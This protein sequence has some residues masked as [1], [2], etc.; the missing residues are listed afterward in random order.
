MRRR[1]RLYAWVRRHPVVPDGALAAGL[2]LVFVVLS[3][4]AYDPAWAHAVLGGLMCAALVFRRVRPVESFAVVSAAGLVQWAT[5]LELTPSDVLLLVGLYS[6]SGY[7]PRW[8]SRVGL[9]T[10]FLGVA[11]AS[12]RYYFYADEGAQSV[13]ASLITFSALVVGSW[14]MGDVRRVRQAYVAELVERAHQAERDRDQRALIAAAEERARI[15]REMHDVV[16]HNLS[17]IVVQADGG[18]YAAAQDPQAA[19]DALTIIGDTGRGA[20]AEMRRLLGVLRATD[21]G[22]GGGADQ[23]IVRNPQPGL[24]SLPELVTSV[25]QAGLPVEFDVSGAPR[26]LPPG[27]SLAV[28]RVI[29]EAL[30]NALKHAGPAARAQ[31]R[32][33][34]GVDCLTAR[35]SDDGRGAA[36]AG[37][38]LGQGLLG[39]RERMT[40]YGGTVTAGPLTGGGWRVDMDMPYGEGA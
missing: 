29:Q 21:D 16:A 33:A 17:V 6:V 25:R 9:A 37:D 18:R 36:A 7:G 40:M 11:L 1:D 22:D 39:M 32:L 27:P 13:V 5:G 23:D 20:L 3:A 31:V 35:V 26:P 8:A 4:A 19:A 10:G 2:F 24:G 28:Y 30:T 34:F 12:S 15:A 14:A 38:G